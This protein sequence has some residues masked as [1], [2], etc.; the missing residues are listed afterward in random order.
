M[1]VDKIGLHMPEH[2]A[3]GVLRRNPRGI[4]ERAGACGGGEEFAG[5]FG[6]LARH[7]DRAVPGGHQRAV[8]GGEHLL[9][10]A[11]R[12]GADGGERVGDADDG[13]HRMPCASAARV[14]QRW[15]VMPQ[16]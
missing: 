13:Q 12:I 16:S 15:P 2:A 9:G 11:H 6:P 14:R 7:D 8:E 3:H 1:E 5:H 4:V 10:A